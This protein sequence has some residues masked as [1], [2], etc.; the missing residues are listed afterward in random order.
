MKIFLIVASKKKRKTKHYLSNKTEKLSN[1]QKS[2][3]FQ[4][5]NDNNHDSVNG[6]ILYTQV[7]ETVIQSLM[8]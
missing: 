6:K 2:E 1:G 4:T 7:K 3:S 8:K 5:S